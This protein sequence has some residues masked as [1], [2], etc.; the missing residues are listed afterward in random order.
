M[1]RNDIQKSLARE[2]KLRDYYRIRNHVAAA[3]LSDDIYTRIIG[4]A[5]YKALKRKPGVYAET[6]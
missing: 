6:R 1:D 4:T 2:F 5:L 3:A